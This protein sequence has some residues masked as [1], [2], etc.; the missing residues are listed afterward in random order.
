MHQF[1]SGRVKRGHAGLVRVW[2]RMHAAEVAAIMLQ[3][4]H[5]CG[6]TSGRHIGS[7][8]TCLSA[9]WSQCC[10][11]ASL[12]LWHGHACLRSAASGAPCRACTPLMFDPSFCLY[13]M[14]RCT[15]LSIICRQVKPGES[16]EQLDGDVQLFAMVPRRRH[17]CLL[18]TQGLSLQGWNSET[19]AI[20]ASCTISCAL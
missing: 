5:A 4:V 19:Y 10:M 1:D 8:R 17:I 3:G 12:A 11:H 13:P 15:E 14:Q 7:V 16:K 20:I 6:H 2:T 18:V 9:A